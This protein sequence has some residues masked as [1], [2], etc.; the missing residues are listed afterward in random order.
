MATIG[1]VTLPVFVRVGDFKE[2]EIGTLT[3]DF[4]TRNGR[5]KAPSTR[6]IKAALKKALR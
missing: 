1:T 5:I 4:E 3:L 2:A 6:E